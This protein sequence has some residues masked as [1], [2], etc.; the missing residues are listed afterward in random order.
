MSI[1]TQDIRWKQR[2]INFLNAFETLVDALELANTRQ[3]S[4]LEQQGL[5]QGFEFTHELAWNVMKDYLEYKGFVDLIDS[6]D[7]T[8]HY[9]YP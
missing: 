6:R 5:I 1:Q 4:K 9:Y 8:R 3:L 2:F 7:A